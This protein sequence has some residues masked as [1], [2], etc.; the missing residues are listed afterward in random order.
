M[1]SAC[2]Y[3]FP[4]GLAVHR[5][6]LE[7]GTGFQRDGVI[8]ASGGTNTATDAAITID[9]RHV[10]IAYDECFCAILNLQLSLLI[11]AAEIN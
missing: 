3:G 1:N 8:R 2:F 5:G 11:N 9:D 4:Q 7:T 6:C 10:L